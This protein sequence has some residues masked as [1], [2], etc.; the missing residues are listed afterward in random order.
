[1]TFILFKYML[2]N[3]PDYPAFEIWLERIIFSVDFPPLL[4]PSGYRGGCLVAQLSLPE[5]PSTS[6]NS[7][8]VN[9]ITISYA[10]LVRYS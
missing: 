3:Q 4:F 6:R 10:V 9:R 8:P 1:M 7:L 5:N 2:K